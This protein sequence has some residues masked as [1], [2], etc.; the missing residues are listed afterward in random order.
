MWRHVRERA[1]NVYQNVDQLP[2]ALSQSSGKRDLIALLFQSCT[3]HGFTMVVRFSYRGRV[4]THKTSENVICMRLCSRSILVIFFP[5]YS[6]RVR[7]KYF[8]TG[9]SL[10]KINHSLLTPFSKSR[11]NS[12]L[13]AFYFFLYLLRVWLTEYIY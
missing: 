7:E 2:E 5:L 13:L 3:R 11:L 1:R 12:P 8:W 10:E 9:Y 6:L 4:I